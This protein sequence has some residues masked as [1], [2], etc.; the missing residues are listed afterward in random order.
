ML[1]CHCRDTPFGCVM[2]W[3]G[4]QTVGVSSYKRDR[5]LPTVLARFGKDN[6]DDSSALYAC[7]PL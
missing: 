1:P 3:L 5:K 7:E 2:T 4:Q 6:I